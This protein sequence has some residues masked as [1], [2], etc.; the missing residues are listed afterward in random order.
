VLNAVFGTAF[1]VDAR[2]GTTR[3][4]ARNAAGGVEVIDAPPDQ[5]VDADA[6][7]LVCDKDLTESEMAHLRNMR[8]RPVA[9]VLNKSDTY[10]AAQLD[11][12]LNHIR[13]RVRG[14]VQPERV[15]ACAADPVR[16]VH[17]ERVDGTLSEHVV[18]T[19]ADVAAILEAVQELITA[20]GSS[21]RVRSRELA[22]R[23]ANAIKN[24]WIVALCVCCA[25]GASAKEP[26]RPKIV[27]V[28]HLAVYSKDLDQSR[29]F[30]RDFLGHEHATIG[31]TAYFRI[32]GRQFLKVLP[33][34]EGGS[35][36][37]SHISLQTDDV[38]AM[39]AYLIARGVAA[40]EKVSKDELGNAVLNVKDPEGHT[41]EFVQYRRDNLL[42]RQMPKHL[43]AGSVSKRLMHVGIIVT[44]LEPEMKFY[45]DVLGFREFWRGSSNGTELSW[46]NLRLPDSEDY[47]ELMLYKQAPAPTERGPAHHQCLEVS[48]IQAALAALEAR[49]NRK[50]YTRTL[51]V[52]TGRNRKRQLNV[53][54]PDGTRTELMEPVTVDGQPAPSSDAPPP[55]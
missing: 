18:P 41:V 36:R 11:G 29:A 1:S 10:D 55:H 52:R 15:L 37:L 30:Y 33:E 7:L 44:A 17:R 8:G 26:A 6:Y 23:F 45:K 22:G 39:R 50:D 31:K 51:E 2:S 43:T 25:A 47:I 14:L 4:A 9:I 3:T 46:I 21:V 28:S 48:D 24:Q 49:P 19:Q 53:F 35:D 32:N 16:I 42:V 38:N 34:R 12:L 13:N 54:D 27:G 5:L 20:A 40:P